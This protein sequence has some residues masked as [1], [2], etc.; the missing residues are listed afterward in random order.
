MA[1]TVNITQ[2]QAIKSTLPQ[3][4]QAHGMLEQRMLAAW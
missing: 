3:V 4:E 1:S 2:G